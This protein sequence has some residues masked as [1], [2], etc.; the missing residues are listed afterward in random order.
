MNTN[1]TLVAKVT[2]NLLMSH[3]INENNNKGQLH[4]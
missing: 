2:N 3:F 4:S 1:E